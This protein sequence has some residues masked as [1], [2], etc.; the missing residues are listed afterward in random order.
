[1]TERRSRRAVAPYGEE[2]RA[3]AKVG[4]GSCPSATR[5][6]PVGCRGALRAGAPGAWRRGG[7][8]RRWGGGGGGGGGRGA[9]FFF[10]FLFLRPSFGRQESVH[11]APPPRGL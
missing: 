1:M 9:V 8:A 11:T 4:P 5:R 7:G 6:E 10:F 2:R 3:L